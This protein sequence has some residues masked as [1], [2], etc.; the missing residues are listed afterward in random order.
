[1]GRIVATVDDKVEK[2]F[3]IT[4]IK[5]KGMKPSDVSAAVEEAMQLWSK[6]HSKKEQEEDQ[7]SDKLE[8]DTPT[9]KDEKSTEEPS[10]TNAKDT[11]HADAKFF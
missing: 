6:S 1:M 10:D 9:L 3:R 8:Q 2:K 5:V 11:N 4:V 7:D